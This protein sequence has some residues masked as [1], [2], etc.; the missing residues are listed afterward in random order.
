MVTFV[1][2]SGEHGVTEMDDWIADYNGY[3]GFKDLLT[4]LMMLGS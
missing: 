4:F 3:S 1:L 2:T